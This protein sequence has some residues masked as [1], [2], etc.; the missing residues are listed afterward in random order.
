MSYIY[1]HVTFQD[2]FLRMD[3]NL[4]LIEIYKKKLFSTTGIQ[5]MHL[6]KKPQVILIPRSCT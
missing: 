3:I 4:I 5:K 6:I 2:N 1:T